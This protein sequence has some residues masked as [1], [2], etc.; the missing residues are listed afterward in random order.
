MEGRAEVTG[1]VQW[2]EPNMMGPLK[3]RDFPLNTG[4][5]LY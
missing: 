2:R 4:E 1:T 3:W 5:Q